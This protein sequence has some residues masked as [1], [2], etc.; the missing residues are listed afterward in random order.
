MALLLGVALTVG[1][2]AYVGWE[3]L[4][5]SVERVG[6]GGFLLYT[7]YNLLSFLPLGWAWWAVA[8]GVGAR[9]WLLLPWGRLVRESASDVLPFSQ[10]GGLVVGI[11]VVQ[12]QGLPESLAIASQIADLTA[13]MAA[14]LFYTLFGV[15]ML[16]AI[17]SHATAAGQLL[18]TSI[19]ALMVGA[20]GLG[21]FV[22]LQ[23]RSLDLIG[24]IAGRWLPDTRERAEAIKTVLRS[25][26]ARPGRVAG[27]I[28]LHGFAWVFSG[29]GS[30]LAL[31]LMGVRVELWKVLTL[32]SLMAAVK[33][34]A[35]MT[36]GGL[37]FQESAYVL[38]APLFGLTPEVTLAVALLRRAKDLTIG[39]PAMLAWQYSE[40]AAR[41]RRTPEPAA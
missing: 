27:A 31:G 13:E 17:L 30:W 5:R 1:A 6:F 4:L 21:A 7:A 18:W 16:L 10:V 11:R 14:Q 22:A 3:G 26:Y 28:L 19:A 8:P 33:S 23:G 12:Q 9:R 41:R 20:V 38:V 15:A 25:I 39:V 32:E 24:V 2:V 34:V 40:L 35:F 36:P 37:G 29:A